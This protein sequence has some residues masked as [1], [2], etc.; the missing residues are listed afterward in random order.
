MFGLA[1]KRIAVQPV[2]ISV[3]AVRTFFPLKKSKYQVTIAINIDEVKTNGSI[4]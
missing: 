4:I 3:Q 2:N 1:L